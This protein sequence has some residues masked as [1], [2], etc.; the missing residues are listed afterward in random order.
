MLRLEFAFLL[1]SGMLRLVVPRPHREAHSN[2][3]GPLRSLSTHGLSHR[4]AALEPGPL[5]GGPLGSASRARKAGGSL[6]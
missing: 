3:E 5:Q 4:V 1:L 2:L 6:S